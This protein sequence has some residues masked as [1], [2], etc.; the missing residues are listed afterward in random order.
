MVSA[1]RVVIATLCGVLCGL[2]CWGLAASGSADLPGAVAWNIVTSR[3]L[4]GLV[5]GISAAKL[6]HWA[7]HGLV[8]GALFSVPLAIGSTMADDPEM[9][10]ASMFAASI[11]MGMIYGVLTELITSVLFKARAY[12]A[13][14]AAPAAEPAPQPAGA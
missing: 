14:L 2:V 9:S 13:E 12:R 6:G 1:K 3:I 4:L 7:I 5:I 8:M 11:V 10:K